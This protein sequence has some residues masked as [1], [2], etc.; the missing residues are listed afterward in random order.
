MY[1]F[2]FTAEAADQGSML[3]SY[4]PNI[5]DDGYMFDDDSSINYGVILITERGNPNG[6]ANGMLVNRPTTLKF[7]DIR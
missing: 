4:P 7:K 1:S 5:Y 3:V 2:T 6:K